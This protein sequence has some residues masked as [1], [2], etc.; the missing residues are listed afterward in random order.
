MR[1]ITDTEI[2]KKY[3]REELKIIFRV[4]Y[5]QSQSQLTNE[6]IQKK[7]VEALICAFVVSTFPSGA[8]MTSNLIR[9][10][11]FDL[12]TL[13]YHVK[14]QLLQ[15]ERV[16]TDELK[17]GYLCVSTDTVL[18]GHDYL[19]FFTEHVRDYLEQQIEATSIKAFI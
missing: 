10:N 18:K 7:T 2:L 4:I 3:S 8:S 15:H 11:C 17:P 12:N 16:V 13:F 19:K 1:V 9:A 5:N 14:R 6:F